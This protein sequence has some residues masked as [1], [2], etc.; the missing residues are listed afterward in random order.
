ME[1]WRNPR[2]HAQND[3]ELM[4]S[5]P[6]FFAP[7]HELSKYLGGLIERH[8]A[9]KNSRILEVGCNIGRTLNWL[10]S[11]GFERVY[12]VEIS[13][14]A[15]EEAWVRFPEIAGRISCQD[16][17]SYLATK[18]SRSFDVIF[19]QS[20]LMHVSPEE[21]VLFRSMA[22]VAREVIMTNEQ[23]TI[24]P[25]CTLERWKWGRNY[26]EVFEPL[27]WRQIWARHNN[28]VRGVEHSTT[29]VFYRAAK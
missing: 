7:L 1:Y 3:D 19:T 22:R 2:L 16:G 4:I 13:P 28:P 10:I 14:E 26:R 9:D 21:D 6:D 11:N 18:K 29:R 24:N 20:C 17:Q 23:E 25:G 8:V 5:M 27:G 15:V 12:G